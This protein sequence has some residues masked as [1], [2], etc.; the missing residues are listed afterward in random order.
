MFMGFRGSLT[1]C[2]ADARLG[3]ELRVQGLRVFR[4]TGFGFTGVR[5]PMQPE[6]PFASVC[7]KV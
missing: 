7:L 3:I 5:S 6:E 2:S 4:V 1:V